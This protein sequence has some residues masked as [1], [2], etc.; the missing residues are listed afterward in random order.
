MTTLRQIKIRFL[1]KQN[2]GTLGVSRRS[3]TSGRQPEQLLCC[4]KPKQ[5]RL[6]AR[7]ISPAAI[8][9]QKHVWPVAGERKRQIEAAGRPCQ[10]VKA[11]DPGL[12]LSGSDAPARP[13][14]QASPRL[15]GSGKTGGEGKKENKKK[16]KKLLV[17]PVSPRGRRPLRAAAMT[18]SHKVRLICH[19]W[20]L[21]ADSV[22]SD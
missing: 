10:R 18:R 14:T 15:R 17:S 6:A 20:F 1:K 22:S 16:K 9:S 7:Y 2:H 19:V 13:D 21:F 12:K 4:D 8:K 5:T 3:N 11:A